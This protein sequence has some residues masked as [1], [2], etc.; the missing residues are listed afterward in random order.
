MHR[1]DIGQITNLDRSVF[2]TLWPPTNYYHELR[3]QLAH[4]LVA[5]DE[6]KVVKGP[7]AK[8]PPDSSLARLASRIKRL[9]LSTTSEPLPPTQR[10]IVGFTGSWIMAGEGHI[11]SIAVREPYRRQ[12]IGELLLISLID[13][14][15]EMAASIIT[16]EVRA[17]NAAA[18]H[19][20]QK[21]GFSQVGLRRGYYK[22]NREDAVLMTIEDLYSPSFEARLNQLKQA[23]SQKHGKFSPSHTG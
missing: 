4:Y 14:M 12:G 18:Q 21:Y 6:D 11:T 23:H 3:N 10:Y 1:E 8:S 13:L 16:L 15:I 22:D 19:L 2:P 9:F 5:Y 7:L 20:Y 17:S